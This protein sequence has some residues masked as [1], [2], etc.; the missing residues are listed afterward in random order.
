MA[1]K[2]IF[3]DYEASTSTESQPLLIGITSPSFGGKTFSAL[4]LAT[5]IQKVLGGDIYGIDTEA[6]R[7]LHYRKDFKFRHVPFPPPH[8][9][10]SYEAAIMHCLNKGAKVIVV[11][12]MT[13]EHSGD[14]GVLDMIDDYIERRVARKKPNEDEWDVRDKSKWTA[15]IAPKA[16]RKHLNTAIEAIGSKAVLIFC[17]RADD[18]TKP[19]AGGK[20]V[21]VGWQ[22]ETTSKLPYMMT[23]RFL[24]PPA[25][26]G[27]PN[28]NPD[29]EFEKLSIK[30]PKQFRDWFKPGLQLN[31]ELGERLARWSVEGSSTGN[32]SQPE[33][34][35]KRDPVAG[36]TALLALGQW[37]DAESRVLA[38][39]H[40][41]HRSELAESDIDQLTHDYRIIKV[42][43]GAFDKIFPPL[44]EGGAQG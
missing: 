18:K 11:D 23:I 27:H 35:K 44:P 4:R 8:N 31:E 34:T 40:K 41:S 14:G 22:A 16:E 21:H 7:M 26:D 42:D 20:P 36:L 19:I 13:H 24:L 39:Y 25:S 12:S 3:Q 29:T 9:P 38:A 15:Q 28:L 1:E 43:R 17:Y 32:G 2:R 33:V 37:P 10:A 5:G 6:N 30:M